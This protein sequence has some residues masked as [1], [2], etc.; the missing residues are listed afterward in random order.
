[1]FVS[2]ARLAGDQ[3]GDVWLAEA[4]I[5]PRILG[6][7]KPT[8]FQ[9]YL[10]QQ[11]PNPVPTGG[12]FADGRPRTR[13]ELSDYDSEGSDAP[14]IRGH[15]RYWHKDRVGVDYLQEEDPDTKHDTQHTWI[16]PVRRGV[17]FNFQIRFENLSDAELGALLWVLD[18][19]S[20]DGY[21]LSLGMGKPYGMGA[22]AVRSDLHLSDREAR[23]TR[24]FAGDGWASDSAQAGDEAWTRA[25]EA[26]ERFVLDGLEE[27]QARRLDELERIQMLLAML[28]WPGPDPEETRYLEI[29]REDPSAKRGKVNEYKERPVLPDPMALAGLPV[30]ESRPPRARGRELPPDYRRGT[31]KKFGLG[32]R[33]SYGFIAPEGGG[34]DVFVHKSNLAPG[35][36]TLEENQ[37]V[38]FLL[39]RGTKGPEAHDVEPE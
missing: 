12:R 37:R 19:A 21:R 28:S 4:P 34:E 24:L 35:V 33:R 18:R 7:P 27:K 17:V 32:A 26:F 8:T 16:R 22:V 3:A 14:V 30:A 1:V 20:D 31:V 15:K 23:Y 36:E 9:H 5:V 29:E 11:Q 13:M 2:D 39:R 6:G 10:T 25:V 38:V